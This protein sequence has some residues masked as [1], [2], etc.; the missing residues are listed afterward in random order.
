MYLSALKLKI[1]N[2]Q[3]RFEPVVSQNQNPVQSPGLY[4]HMLPIYMTK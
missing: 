1:K 2:P 3:P 4:C